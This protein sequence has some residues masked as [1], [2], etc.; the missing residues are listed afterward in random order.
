[1][2]IRNKSNTV[3]ANGQEILPDSCM[4]EKTCLAN[5]QRNLKSKLK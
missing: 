1:M 3:I 5:D 2:I 4:V